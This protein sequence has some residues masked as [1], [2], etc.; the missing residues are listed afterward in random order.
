MKGLAVGRIVHYRVAVAT[1]NGDDGIRPAI[2]TKVWN[3]DGMVNLVVFYDGS[4][5][6]VVAAAAKTSVGY[7]EEDKVGYWHWP[8]QV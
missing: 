7:A 6:R 4:Y 3:I 8:Q 1:E 2:I 5:D